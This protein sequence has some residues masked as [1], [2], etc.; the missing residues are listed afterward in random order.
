MK[1]FFLIIFLLILWNF[2]FAAPQITFD[3]M[4]H[5]FGTLKEE[6]G[7]AKFTFHF[8]NTGDE[9]LKILRVKSS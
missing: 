3:T 8:T 9:P 6:G 4:K 2:I 7:K 5:D 1:K